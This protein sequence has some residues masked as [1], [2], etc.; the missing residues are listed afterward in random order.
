[1]KDQHP[2]NRIECQY[3][4]DDMEIMQVKKFSG[5]WPITLI[6]AG[7]FCTLFFVGPLIGLPMLLIGIYMATAEDTIRFCPSCGNFYRIWIK[8]EQ[9]L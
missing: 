4:A 2:K 7:L 1:M 3:C 8:D 6:V 9:I 5:K